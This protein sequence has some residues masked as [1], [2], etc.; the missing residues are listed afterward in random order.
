MMLLRSASQLIRADSVK[1]DVNFIFFHHALSSSKFFAL[2]TAFLHAYRFL[3][4]HILYESNIHCQQLNM[5]NVCSRK[6]KVIN[7]CKAV[8]PKSYT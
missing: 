5:N 3:V 8:V 1:D 2:N 7:R 6:K 4:G